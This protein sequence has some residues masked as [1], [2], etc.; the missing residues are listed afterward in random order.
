MS[1]SKEARRP[2]TVVIIGAGG[3]G[4]LTYAPYAKK[5]P[6]QM[7]V[8]G[9]AEPD[10]KRRK[11]IQEEYRLSSENCFSTAEELFSAPRFADMAFICT[12]DHQHVKHGLLAMEAGYDILLEKPIS[13]DIGE[14][15]KLNQRA[16]EL[17]RFVTVCHVLRYA[18]FY[19][20]IKELIDRGELGEVVCIQ[21]AENVGYW[22]QTHSYVRGKWRDAD[23]TSP[24]ILAKSCHDMDI[25]VWLTGSTCKTVS[26][27]GALTFF[28]KENA[29]EGA[30]SHCL[31]GC[32]VKESCCFDAEK[33]YV[34]DALT[35]YDANGAGWMQ[36]AVTPSGDRESLYEALR[37]GPY[38]RCVFR[39]DNNVV[40]HQTLSAVMKNGVS[41][42]FAM[43]GL[44]SDNYR[45][46]H[47]MGT[48]GDLWG[49]LEKEKILLKP[50]GKEPEEIR[51]SVEETVSGHGGGDYHMLSEMFQ[52]RREGRDSLTGLEES[53]A[54][55]YMALAAERSRQLGGKC[56][57]VDD[58][59]TQRE[60]TDGR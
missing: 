45:T 8:V 24:M 1:E 18:P 14:C 55:H 43:C 6:E 22:H 30:P 19:Q 58:F 32:P 41:I 57:D 59:V 52:A 16:R 44:N 40:D 38:G 10:E 7:K 27:V 48:K 2:V 33:I 12:Q 60:G 39:C 9:V 17:K 51:L 11:M 46:I 34:T 13:A 5:Y 56:L 53:L 35:G 37:T 25:L 21:A 28:Q 26:S 3:R 47:V 20:K 31:R 42:S 15:Q 4:Y 29:P 54:S 50:F 23:K 36:K 49:E